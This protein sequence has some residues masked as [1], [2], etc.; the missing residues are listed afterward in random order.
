MKFLTRQV[1]VVVAI[2]GCLLGATGESA[3]QVAAL[4]EGPGLSARHPGDRGI[5]RDSA[6]LFADDFEEGDLDAIA[7]RWGEMSNKGGRVVRLVEDDPLGKPGRAIEMT[8]TLGENT[9]GHLYTRLKRPVETVFARF[10]VKFPPDTG[11][12][13]H[14]VHLGGY[15]PPTPWP[16]G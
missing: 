8:S 2:V 14:F 16:Q 1:G 3:A 5:D 9:G 12:V 10:Y 6:V 15:N 13:H 4:P 7:R 11:Y